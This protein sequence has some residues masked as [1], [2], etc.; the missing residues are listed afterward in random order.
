LKTTAVSDISAVA[1]MPLVEFAFYDTAVTDIRPLLACPTLERVG[2][3]LSVR[4]IEPLRAHP[5]IKTLD[6]NYNF[7]TGARTAER[8]WAEWDETRGLLPVEQFGKL[9]DVAECAAAAEYYQDALNRSRAQNPPRDSAIHA[10]TA[11]LAVVASRWAEVETSAKRQT[12]AVE[13][14]NWARQLMGT[15]PDSIGET[16]NKSILRNIVSLR[17]RVGDWP[18]TLEALARLE[19]LAP[20][21]PPDRERLL[22][23]YVDA[24]DLDRATAFGEDMLTRREKNKHAP[25]AILSIHLMSV[26]PSLA[27][28]P[29]VS[30]LLEFA[31][32]DPVVQEKYKD[33]LRLAQGL[34]AFRAGRFAESIEPLAEVGSKCDTWLRAYAL[35]ALAMAQHQLG[36]AEEARAAL[37]AAEQARKD[38]LA[39]G[40]PLGF[41]P[42]CEWQNVLAA[43]L[44][45][46]EAVALAGQP[47]KPAAAA[48]IDAKSA[49]SLARAGNFADAA[50]VTRERFARVGKEPEVSSNYSAEH[51]IFA[52][53][54]LAAGDR[55]GY[56]AAC[57]EAV[58]SFGDSTSVDH[59]ERIG[60]ACLLAPDSGI[61][62]ATLAA[63]VATAQPA[64]ENR[65][66]AMWVQL[67]NAL[68]EYRA[69]HFDTA[70]GWVEKLRANPDS[71]AR[72]LAA[73]DAI[74]AM[75]EHHRQ[76]SA[77]ARA[78]LEAA[79]K[80]VAANWPAGGEGA[81]HAWLIA[82]LLTKEAA[83]LL[84]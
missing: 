21:S 17:G 4:D 30:K 26:L 29:R 40:A 9:A 34:V 78:A 36:H 2:L 14:A 66:H 37:T 74:L 24:G 73:A 82:D 59:A 53:A 11:S 33:V 18:R 50:R 19:E 27:G 13:K 65:S 81:W 45:R 76:R 79:Q 58:R 22:P 43:D 32:A 54:L 56:R 63:I 3:S 84:R 69:G 72:G 62:P 51:L 38:L 31:A 52:A 60:K 49:E 41:G 47:T 7:D 64:L 71:P 35:P 1:T 6:Y 83:T 23:L 57:A 12:E 15:L 25:S 67:L 5:G 16:K 77:E 42:R 61:E 44:L 28:N 75:A 8:F 48:P 20:G 70:A 39:L 55:E 68:A 10:A 46:R 80:S